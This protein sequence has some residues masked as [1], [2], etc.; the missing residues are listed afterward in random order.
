M[1]AIFPDTHP[2]VEALLIRMLREAPPWRRL[3]MVDQLNQGVKL[4]AMAGL[5]E[6]HPGESEAKLRRRLAGL[7]LGEELAV[8]AYGPLPEE[9]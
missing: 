5:R 8:K 7:L 9:D 3:E 4:L 6:R 2:E 1:S